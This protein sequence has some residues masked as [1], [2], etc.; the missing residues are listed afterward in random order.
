MK[1]LSLKKANSPP[2][3]MLFLLL[4]IIAYYLCYFSATQLLV[5]KAHI[6]FKSSIFLSTLF[7]TKI[8]A[9]KKNIILKTNHCEN[10][11]QMTQWI[12]SPYVC[13]A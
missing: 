12:Y 4:R 6:V 1:Y 9:I 2:K 10:S 7:P 3:K 8:D 5:S 13:I 11:K